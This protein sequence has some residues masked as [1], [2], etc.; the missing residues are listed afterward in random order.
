MLYAEV[1]PDENGTWQVRRERAFPVALPAE[2][3]KHIDGKATLRPIILDSTVP[4]G[5]RSLGTYTYVIEPTQVQ[6]N[7]DTEALTSEEAALAALVTV[8]GTRA[9]AYRAAIS[10]IKG[11]PAASQISVLGFF[12]DA[13]ATMLETMRVA[14][15]V[16]ATQ[17]WADFL[18]AVAAV[19]AQYPKP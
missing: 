17:E 11:D 15:A 13:M 8:L 18:T 14:A 3:I 10:A 12:V 19:K 16:P 6:K 5:Y 2:A 9:E 4:G 1:Y 7:L